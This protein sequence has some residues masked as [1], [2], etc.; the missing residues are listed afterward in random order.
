MTS[1]HPWVV[2]IGPPASGKTKIGRRVAS[3][4]GVS[5]RDTDAM[6]V[7]LHGAIP[8]IFRRDG[9]P[10]FRELERLAV[11]EALGHDGVVSLGGGA[12][13]H[14]ETRGDLAHHTVVA[15]TISPEAVASRLD[16]DKRPLLTDGLESWK[17][18]VA[19]RQPLYD[20]VATWQL[21]VSHRPTEQVAQEIVSWLEHRQEGHQ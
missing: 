20:E 13:T 12:V 16:N 3:L 17:N 1:Q 4:L 9:E 6:V 5:H 18:L 14:P 2:L 7:A 8:D 10:A 21:D 11:R 19:S 15:L